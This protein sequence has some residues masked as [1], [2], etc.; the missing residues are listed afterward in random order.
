MW[1]VQPPQAGGGLARL[2]VLGIEVS[3]N[4]TVVVEDH[5]EQR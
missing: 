2:T 4:A 1:H 5:G 3:D